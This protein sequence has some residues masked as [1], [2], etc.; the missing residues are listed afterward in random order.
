MSN[1]VSFS[2]LGSGI[3]F[4]LIRDAILASR[5]RSVTL[6]QSQV[7]DYGGRIEA[8]KALNTGLAGLTTASQALTNR[9][10]GFGRATTTSDASIAVAQAASSTAVGTYNLN[11][12]RLA[13]NLTQV[14]RSYAS[15]DTAVL[16]GAATEATFEL[17]KGGAA[18]GT[19]ITIDS[20]NNTLAGLRDAINNAGAGVNASI[21]DVNGDGTGFQ[22]VLSSDET[23]A[24]GRVE[25]VET[26]TTGTGADL[27]ISAV[28]PSS[29]DF[30]ELNAVF[31]INGLQVTRGTN[32]I[33]D[34]ISGVTFTIKSVG[35]TTISVVS[36]NDIENKLR[37]FVNQYNAIQD[38]IKEQY[39]KDS[40]GRPTG[41]LAGEST[42]R[43]AQRQ[44][45][46]VLRTVSENNGGSLTSLADIGVKVVEGGRLDLDTSIL[47]ERLAAN[48]ADVRAVLYGLTETDTGIFQQV[49]TIVN[50]LGDS[51]SGSVQVAI[52]GYQSSIET[53]NKSITKRLGALDRLRISLTRQFAVADAAIAQLNG[54]GSALTGIIDSLNAARRYNN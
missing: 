14:T 7:K 2:G 29:G 38:F 40:L 17:R 6:L 54:Q 31:S 35:S 30:S 51:I 19:A 52:N 3:D 9:T 33:D 21:I 42:L 43:S 37:T 48:P 23:G 25:L 32:V 12:T 8:L 53:T 11:I 36:G 28:N 10:L 39:K 49:E 45:R 24:A 18:E 22:I 5:S 44:L 15:K 13:T 16:A 27:S 46:D 47:N 41:A 26:T 4:N 1:G 34:T 50:G 20:S